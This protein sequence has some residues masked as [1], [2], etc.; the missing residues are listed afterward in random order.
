MKDDCTHSNDSSNDVE[1]WIVAKSIY[2]KYWQLPQW[3]EIAVDT[4]E[5]T[6]H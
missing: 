5:R 2:E 6:I 3:G 1:K 4:M